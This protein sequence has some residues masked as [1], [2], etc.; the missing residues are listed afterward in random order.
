MGEIKLN[1]ARKWRSKHFE[2]IVGQDMSVRMLKNSLFLQQYFPVYL[3]SGQRGC[4]K[5]S[6]ARVFAS[7]LNCDK[8]SEF[9]SNPRTQLPC[10]S[11]GS[12]KAME[13]GKHPD[14]IEI[15]AA[16]HT[17]VDHVRMLI[18]SASLLPLMGK[19]KIYLIDEAHMLSKAAFN[20]L[21]KILE[22]PPASVIFMLATT[23][24]HKIIETVRSRCFQLFF[25]PI[26]TDVLLERL[27]LI[28]N[29]EDISY[30]DAGLSHI[31]KQADGSVRDALNLLETVR[32]SSSEITQHAVSG[33]LGYL[34][35]K[36]LIALC[37]KVLQG[38]TAQVI[39]NIKKLEWQRYA[40][41]IIWQRLVELIRA[42]LWLKHDVVPEQFAESIDD[43]KKMIHAVSA[44][45]LTA[46]LKMLYDKE[47]VFLKTTAK[48]DVLEMVLM[49]MS[50]KIKKS[51][52]DDGNSSSSNQ[53]LSLSQ[54]EFIDEEVDEAD[55]A[56]EEDEEDDEEEE[57]YEE[58]EAGVW[59]KFV[60]SLEILDDP[61]VSSVF[62]Q[63]KITKWA[64]SANDART[65]SW[66]CH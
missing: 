40:A 26:E 2:E 3:F 43:I 61:L 20:A 59:K 46:F 44:H 30:E 11:C 41:P 50:E 25:R 23:D 64:L 47:L 35:D 37:G 5:T 60:Q 14:F 48:H 17:G 55:E 31:V 45:Q 8:L 36:D 32:F 7:A 66:R 10:M 52:P 24:P 19:K 34:D 4:G 63:G 56:D 58:E 9:R 13:Q 49:Q 53:A 54:P 29:K 39:Q 57:D 16:S 21:L 27:Q 38:N 42:A 33:V 65:V 6:T 22:E 51:N 15:D 12:C 1:L 62:T 18:D 28:C